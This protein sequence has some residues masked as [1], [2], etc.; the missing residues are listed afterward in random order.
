MSVLYLLPGLLCDEV[1]WAHQV[2]GLADL[3]QV[4]VPVF[5]GF[6]SLTAMAE[7][8]LAD[9][10]GRFAVAGPAAAWIEPREIQRIDRSA[11]DVF[12]SRR[13]RRSR[14]TKRGPRTRNVPATT[15]AK[16]WTSW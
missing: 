13:V 15:R 5:Y 4:R 6:H 1:T 14:A 9:A 12:P 2:A 8:V 7:S 10:P 11:H 3:A 16:T